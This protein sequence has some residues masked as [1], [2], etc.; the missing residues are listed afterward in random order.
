MKNEEER[1]RSDLLFFQRIRSLTY[2][3]ASEAKLFHICAQHLTASRYLVPFSLVAS[4][5]TLLHLHVSVWRCWSVTHTHTHMHTP[6]NSPMDY[7]LRICV[8]GSAYSHPT[9]TKEDS[10][11][12]RFAKLNRAYLSCLFIVKD[13]FVWSAKP[14]V[15][16]LLS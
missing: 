16:S 9:S 1:Q 13:G 7:F 14:E 12:E 10:L 3:N 2:Q 5:E 6:V 8:G 11:K 4:L 15:F